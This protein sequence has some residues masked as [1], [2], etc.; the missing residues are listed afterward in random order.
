MLL[1]A[2]RNAL[3]G[4]RASVAADTNE[5]RHTETAREEEM[6]LLDWMRGLDDRV[7]RNLSVD[8]P[9]SDFERWVAVHPA[10]AAIVG[11]VSFGLVFAAAVELPDPQPNNFLLL[12]LLVGGLSFGVLAV[13][14]RVTAS[15]VDVRDRLDDSSSDRD[16]DEAA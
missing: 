1:P 2:G 3:A 15:R 7:E 11:A 16:S 10:R 13:I 14:A 9:V 4:R 12:W 5:A 6:G 8:R